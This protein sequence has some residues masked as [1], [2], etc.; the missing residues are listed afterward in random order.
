[1]SFLYLAYGSNMLTARLRRRCPSARAIGTALILDH[2][3]EFTKPSLDQ[4]G[5][6]TLV[7]DSSPSAC[8]PGVLFEVSKSDLPSLDKAEGA[9]LGYDRHDEFDVR[10]T[11]THEQVTATTYLAIET[12]PHLR[13][14]DWYL[15]LVIAGAQEHGLDSAHIE[16]LSRTEYR[17]DHI[18]DRTGRAEA[19]RALRAHGYSDA[20]QL[21]GRA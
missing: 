13:P 21:L 11:D 2:G 12:R 1:M 16:M 18:A 6:A 7:P 8:T 20:S 19:I 10:L 15:A 17:I 3:L 14:Y 9:F 5:K 4:S